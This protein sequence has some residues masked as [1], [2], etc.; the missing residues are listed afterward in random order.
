[1]FKSL[2]KIIRPLQQLPR[3]G[4]GFVPIFRP[5]HFRAGIFHSIKKSI[6]TI[7]Q[8]QELAS[9]IIVLKSVQMAIMEKQKGLNDPA[10]QD[11]L[12]NYKSLL[13]KLLT[14]EDSGEDRS[15]G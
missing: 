9:Q 2:Q 15:H 3:A 5:Q 13:T 1:M 8:Q 4:S 10:F 11:V 12:S 14:V 6:R 7:K